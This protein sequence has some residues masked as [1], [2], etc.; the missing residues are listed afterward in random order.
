MTTIM[1]MMTIFVHSHKIIPFIVF[2]PFLDICYLYSRI[3]RTSEHSLLPLF[4]CT[5][6]LFLH[7]QM[8]SSLA[9]AKYICKQKGNL[10]SIIF[11]DEKCFNFCTIHT[12][13]SITHITT[14]LLCL[15][16]LIIFLAS[17]FQ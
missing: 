4:F 3:E 8:L 1:A 14:I 6:H 12:L 16:F 10:A 11:S 17:N 15:S 9:L 13:M 2:C 7:K 5:F